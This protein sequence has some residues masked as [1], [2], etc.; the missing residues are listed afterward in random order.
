M[1]D[2][3]LNKTLPR[4]WWSVTGMD[5]SSLWRASS[6]CKRKQH[7][8]E[9]SWCWLIKWKFS[10][11]CWFSSKIQKNLQTG[12]VTCFNS[13]QNIIKKYGRV[14]FSVR[15]LAFCLLED[16]YEWLSYPLKI[17]QYLLVGDWPIE[18]SMWQCGSDSGHPLRCTACACGRRKHNLWLTFA[19]DFPS[20]LV[21]PSLSCHR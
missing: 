21:F 16:L 1:K 19:C 9:F 18:E 5:F 2:Q 4:S 3:K 13:P 8:K 17:T 12:T 6:T 10:L 15:Q 11:W 20:E 7:H 14:V